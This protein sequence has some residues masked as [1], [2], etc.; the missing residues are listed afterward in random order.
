M[1]IIRRFAPPLALLACI[2]ALG[3]VSD[4]QAQRVFRATLDGTQEVPSVTATTAAGTG[5]V[6]LNVAET[7]IAV[8]MSF[9]GLSSNQIAAHIH[10]NSPRGVSSGVLFN[11]GSSGTTSGVFSFNQPV[12]PADVV[13]LKAGLW[14]FNV[15]SANFGGGE[16]RGQIEADCANLPIGLVSWY[17]GEG[18][19]LDQNSLNNGTVLSATTYSSGKVGRTFNF[20]GTANSGVTIPHNTNLDVNPSGFSAEFW[21]KSNG[22][23]AAQVDLLEKSHGF[24]D[25]TGWAFQ[26]E[27]GGTTIGF[28]IGAGG[29]GDTNFIGV[30]SLVNP[31]DG[32]YHHIA[33][34][35]DGSN[36]RLYID[37]V[38]QGTTPFTSPVNNTRAVNIGFASG[39]GTPTRRFNG[40]V[41]EV[42]IFSRSMTA[43][44]I[45]S[46]YNA[47][48]AGKCPPCIG[49]PVGLAEWWTADG[50]ALGVRNRNNGVLSG[51][52]TFSEGMNQ[53]AFSFDG[54]N[55]QVT[56]ANDFTGM[57]RAT[58][59]AW[60]N[61][62]VLTGGYT[63]GTL[64]GLTRRTAA[65]G[66]IDCRDW[67]IGLYGGKLGAFFRNNLGGGCPV[68]VLQANS[69]T[70]QT[71]TWYHVALTLDGGTARLYV[72]GVEQA[73]GATAPNFTLAEQ[74]RIGQAFCCAGDSFGGRVDEVE[75]YSRALSPAEI[76]AAANAGRSCKCKPG[77]T[78]APSGLVG[79]WGGDGDARDISG[80]GINGSLVGGTG[81]AV[82]R[83]GQGFSFDGIDDKVSIPH[84]ANQNTGSQITIEGWVYPDSYGHGRPILEKR[85]AG[86]VGGWDLETVTSPFGNINSLGFY[87]WIGGSVQSLFTPSNSLSVGVWQH[88]AATY[89]G[90]TMRVFVNGVEIASRAQS[91]SIDASTEPLGIGNNVVNPNGFVWHGGLD[92]ISLY[93][94]GLTAA[95]VQ[96]IYNAGLAGKLKQTVTQFNP[97]AE[98]REVKGRDSGVGFGPVTTVGDA[99]IFFQG[100]SNTPG[101]TQWMPILQSKLPRLPTNWQGLTYDIST[102]WQYTGINSVCFRVPSFTPAQ[103]SSLRVYHLESDN[104]VNRT[105]TGSIYPNLCTNSLTSLSPFAIG[106]L[107]PNAANV[108]V[109][110]RVVT[111][112]GNGVS[113]A[114]VYFTDSQGV[115]RTA[116]TGSLGYF[117]FDDVLAGETYVVVIGHKRYTFAPRVVTVED[118][119]TEL[120][121]VAIE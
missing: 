7:S 62:S 77:A 56:P 21:M 3:F 82:G 20:P 116:R 33:G 71:N 95:E 59:Q 110:G 15:H 18:N 36:I 41:D 111:A 121:F 8:T 105:N 42:G 13:N 67:S 54:V 23:Q 89:D 98:N 93:N 17:R 109:G 90:T 80:N 83:V 53:S 118:E 37:G 91:G 120:D 117:R 61:P 32:N 64:P 38:L 29:G 27:P 75:V 39:G 50:S 6:E 88:V 4:A 76:A 45:A 49:T 102:S 26:A 94:R 79:W 35:W 52:A 119:I 73:S 19:G 112:G 113:N 72:D 31:F 55:G 65:G 81:L 70:V 60:I 106:N 11:V 108:N 63:D 2:F 58:I 5:T 10:G 96:S 66:V 87:I 25:S 48:A 34:T 1:T 28:F 97:F 14:Y 103:F 99:T 104:W 22:S 115:T 12:T 51:G 100:T 69:I 40:I 44:E 92:E 24:V 84:N 107:I 86:N 101:L 43:A 68:S 57:T 9:S 74:F 114:V 85:S 46:I 16:I 47:G 30:T 78:A